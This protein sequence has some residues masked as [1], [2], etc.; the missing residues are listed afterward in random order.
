MIPILLSPPWGHCVR[1]DGGRPPRDTMG[2]AS[3][4][5]SQAGQPALALAA[6][7]QPKSPSLAEKTLRLSKKH[8]HHFVP[9]FTK[10]SR[11]LL[12]AWSQN[13]SGRKQPNHPPTT[14]LQGVAA[15]GG[16]SETSQSLAQAEDK[17][18]VVQNDPK[19]SCLSLQQVLGPCLIWG[20]SKTNQIPCPSPQ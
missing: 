19:P 6:A 9:S 17:V 1:G 20:A 12:S 4:E 7:L 15:F 8:P 5:M 3:L 2:P 18:I 10:A 14:E 11:F 16:D 13:S